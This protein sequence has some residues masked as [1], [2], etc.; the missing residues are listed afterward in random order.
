MRLI[1]NE[2]SKSSFF[3]SRGERFMIKLHALM[4][5]ANFFPK[6]NFSK[7]SYRNTISVKSFDPEQAQHFIPST[8][9]M[10]YPKFI[11]SNQKEKSTR[12]LLGQPF[13]PLLYM[14]CQLS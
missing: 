8:C 5:S 3:D 9:T 7:N 6:L 11:V 2:S 1:K 14:H 13:T 12:I 4:L 10:D